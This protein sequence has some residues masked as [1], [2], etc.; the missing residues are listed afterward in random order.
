M[1][2]HPNNIFT[3][4]TSYELSLKICNVNIFDDTTCKIL[5]I[6]IQRS[7]TE[8][9]PKVRN[10]LV[11]ACHWNRN[12]DRKNNPWNILPSGALSKG[13]I[14]N[15]SSGIPRNHQDMQHR[16]NVG[17]HGKQPHGAQGRQW[18]P[19]EPSAEGRSGRELVWAQVLW[20]SRWWFVIREGTSTP[21][22]HQLHAYAVVLFLSAQN[23]H[24]KQLWNFLGGEEFNKLL[25]SLS[26]GYFSFPLGM[27]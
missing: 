18:G 1:T 7:V 25:L 6:H 13:W 23:R 24:V 11:N 19:W 2:F 9:Q 5:Q 17:A 20:G 22:W 12:S 4:Q 16:Q 21:D 27:G 3:K 8:K 10:M 14:A 15:T 26:A